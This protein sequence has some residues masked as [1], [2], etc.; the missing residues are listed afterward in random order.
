MMPQG[1]TLGIMGEWDIIAKVKGLWWYSLINSFCVSGC[2]I[3]AEAAFFTM[4][5]LLCFLKNQAWK[6]LAFNV[7]IILAFS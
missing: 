4:L 3:N 7:L 1:R 6:K 2:D 5:I